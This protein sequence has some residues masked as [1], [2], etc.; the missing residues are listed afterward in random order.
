MDVLIRDVLVLVFI[1]IIVLFSGCAKKELVEAPQPAPK[2]QTIN[3]N[4]LNLSK[5][6]PIRLHVKIK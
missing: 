4:E 5:D 3:I 1:S 6:K 2:L